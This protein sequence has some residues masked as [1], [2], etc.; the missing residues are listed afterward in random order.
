MV[1]GKTP[2]HRFLN[3]SPLRLKI[4]DEPGGTPENPA[5]THVLHADGRMSFTA[6]PR[7]N[8]A[9]ALKTLLAG[10]PFDGAA[11]E[12][13][14][15][16][17]RQ[18]AGFVPASPPVETKSPKADQDRD[19][20]PGAPAPGSPTPLTFLTSLPAPAARVPPQLHGQ[21]AHARLQVTITPQLLK[22]WS[23]DI[24]NAPGWRIGPEAAT[25]LGDLAGI[26][27]ELFMAAE[28]VDP[29]G[30]VIL[31]PMGRIGTRPLPPI[32]PAAPLIVYLQGNFTIV[33]P[34]VAFETP[35]FSTRDGRVYV[36]LTH[37]GA[38]EEGAP[39]LLPVIPRN[40]HGL[41]TA[42]YYL[43]LKENLDGELVRLKARLAQERPDSEVGPFLVEILESYLNSPGLRQP[44][45]MCVPYLQA[46]GC[47]SKLLMAL[48]EDPSF[49]AAC[50][51]TLARTRAPREG[52]DERHLP[53]QAPESEASPKGH[54][55]SS[56]GCSPGSSSSALSVGSA[57][58]SSSSLSSSSSSPSPLGEPGPLALPPSALA[59]LVALGPNGRLR[60]TPSPALLEAVREDLA[61]TMFLGQD[62]ARLLGTVMGVHAG[63]LVARSED[64]QEPVRFV[65][66]LTQVGTGA[67]EH[68]ADAPRILFEDRHYKVV[69]P[70]T[71]SRELPRYVDERGTRYIELTHLAADPSGTVREV[72]VIPA[73]GH[74][75]IAAIFYVQTGMPIYPEQVAAYRAL[76][77]ERMSPRDL[78]ELARDIVTETLRETP[79]DPDAP[80]A[81]S[82]LGPRVSQFL[83]SEASF[84][85]AYRTAFMKKAEEQK[86]LFSYLEVK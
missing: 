66:T 52:K 19:E 36:E 71:D 32:D 26:Q 25:F 16:G 54:P 67:P 45:S 6:F 14:R 47:Q 69:R 79:D 11:H 17:F 56:P 8:E 27:A 77:V 28:N 58:I 39:K 44:E 7:V 63:V 80:G 74:C 4:P 51:I 35:Q 22:A 53:S 15:Y 34:A 24:R 72:P 2:T 3:L 82:G 21:E 9:G 1:P 41:M 23:L 85:E 49:C 38:G 84:T 83:R 61:T 81:W 59:R 43:A 57:S 31:E 68:A 18:F 48:L 12:P 50:R 55:S 29:W 62:E 78:S 42:C 10:M 65:E 37:T 60:I 86:T 30:R 20:A 5:G 70:T 73:D 33:R 76:L 46:V 40:A 64:H 75:L 13:S